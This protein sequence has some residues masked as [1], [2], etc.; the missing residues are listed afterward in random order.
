MVERTILL[1]YLLVSWGSHNTW[2][3][4]LTNPIMFTIII[5]EVTIT[6]KLDRETIL[7]CNDHYFHHYSQKTSNFFSEI[8]QIGKLMFTCKVILFLGLKDQNSSAITVNAFVEGSCPCAY[9]VRGCKGMKP[10]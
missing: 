2:V 3:F 6:R 5:K 4:S 10:M 7:L 1:V 8:V 9:L